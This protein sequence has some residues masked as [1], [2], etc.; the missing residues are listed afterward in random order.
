MFKVL[1]RTCSR[2]RA[3]FFSFYVVTCQYSTNFR[4]ERVTRF[5]SKCFA[6]D[7]SRLLFNRRLKLFFFRS[8]SLSN[9]RTIARRTR[10]TCN[11]VKAEFNSK[12][13][14]RKKQKANNE[15]L[16]SISMKLL[17]AGRCFFC[18]ATPTDRDHF[19]TSTLHVGKHPSYSRTESTRRRMIDRETSAGV[20]H[21]CNKPGCV[22]AANVFIACRRSTNRFLKNREPVLRVRFA[23]N[24]VDE[25]TYTRYMYTPCVCRESF[26]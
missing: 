21:S 15:C 3:L 23:S 26:R 16:N 6:I 24:F 19:S 18:N 20:L 9:Q 4:H 7:I 11:A 14:K 12:R 2:K 1:I 22:A 25:H 5:E 17:V 13:E 8:L 10:V